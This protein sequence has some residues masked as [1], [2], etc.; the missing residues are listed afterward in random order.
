MN[1]K[2]LF[3][4]LSSQDLAEVLPLFFPEKCTSIVQEA[5][6]ILH[7]SLLSLGAFPYLSN[8][9]PYLTLETFQAALIILTN[10]DDSKLRRNMD[11]EDEDVYQ[12]RLDARKQRMIFQSVATLPGDGSSD[13]E[14]TS[15]SA[16]NDEDI[17][18]VYEY[19]VDHNYQDQD[20]GHA[21]I[22]VSGPELPALE[23]FPSSKSRKLDRKVSHQE[24]TALVKV[25][26]ITQLFDT[27]DP[28]KAVEYPDELN[29]TVEFIIRAFSNEENDVDW[30]TYEQAVSQSFVGYCLSS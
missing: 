26:L 23:S 18:E 30:Y 2:D 10:R 7:R 11:N 16:E 29:Q 20:L 17:R 27:V 9:A 28:E 4:A 21:V 5:A 1:L 12:Q 6:P 19:V 13:D 8:P 22:H 24:L 15:R 14:S 3:L 25:L